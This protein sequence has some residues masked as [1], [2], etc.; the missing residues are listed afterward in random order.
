MLDDHIEA[1]RRA[2]VAQGYAEQSVRRKVLILR[3]FDD[4]LVSRRVAVSGITD[5][6][7]DAFLDE[8]AAIWLRR[9]G[10]QTIR[11]FIEMLRAD[12]V[13][14]V[15]QAAK[16]SDAHAAV[17]DGFRD[18]LRSERAFAERTIEQY[19]LR[20]RRFLESTYGSRSPQLAQLR[21]QDFTRHV[22]QVLRDAGRGNA[23]ET[24]APLRAFARYLHLR[25]YVATN[26]SGSVPPVRCV[27]KDLLPKY[28]GPDVVERLLRNVTPSSA[29]ARR[30]RAVL[31]LLAR[32]G[33]RPFEIVHLELDDLLWREGRVRVHG[34]RGRID[35]MPLTQ[36]IGHA[37][38][39]YIRCARPPCVS[40]RVFLCLKAPHRPIGSSRTISDIV[41]KEIVRAGIRVPRTGAYILR[42]SLATTLMSKGSSLQEVGM[43]LRHGHLLSTKTYA[44][45]QLGALRRLAV[46]WPNEV[47]A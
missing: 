25:G 2:V 24:L 32:L 46:A 8:F 3:E 41:R 12:C 29:R 27:E 35:L 31:L 23:K 4:W 33:L 13:I 42:H 16:K 20:V 21:A 36:E 47:R 5:S 9:G 18:H 10:P 6:R 30:N 11:R 44:K 39:D 22:D 37:I 38:A 7:V 43:V 28:V 14:P 45:V 17:V 40:R 26:L 19:S 34:K 1:F 15:A